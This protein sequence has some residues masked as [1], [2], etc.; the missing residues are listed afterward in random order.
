MGELMF[1]DH[2]MKASGPMVAYQGDDVMRCDKGALV[3]KV[4]GSLT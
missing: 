2:M 3:A 1:A 4:A